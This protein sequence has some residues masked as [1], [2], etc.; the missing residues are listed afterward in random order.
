MKGFTFTV[1]HEK[2]GR[3]AMDV[4]IGTVT[5]RVCSDTSV[6]WLG[7]DGFIPESEVDFSCYTQAEMDAWE[8]ALAKANR[9]ISMILRTATRA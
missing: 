9:R 5:A 8:A 1:I 4:T 2:D 3:L 6:L 7:S